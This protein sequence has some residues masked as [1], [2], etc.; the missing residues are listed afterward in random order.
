MPNGPP[1]RVGVPY[2][3]RARLILIYLQ[4]EALRTNSREVELGRSLRV[5]LGR[6]GIPIGGKSMAEVRDQAE[7]IIPSPADQNL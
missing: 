6:M 5:W 3:S 1:V 2:G 7:R 4:S